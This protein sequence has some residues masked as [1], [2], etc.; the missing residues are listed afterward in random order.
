MKRKQKE[1]K[2]DGDGLS[3][4]ERKRQQIK[5][6]KWV[7]AAW[8]G[9]IV[10]MLVNSCASKEQESEVYTEIY[11]SGA[12]I[13]TVTEYKD[14][15]KSAESSDNHLPDTV[16]ERGIFLEAMEQAGVTDFLIEWQ[17]ENLK[18]AMIEITQIADG[19]IWL[20]DVWGITQLNLGGKGIKKIEALKELVLSLIHI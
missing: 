5:K 15:E 8:I 11:S 19:D 16:V 9:I 6:Q 4:Q 7:Q 3:Y 1:K 13:W 10:L 12:G 18:Q 14:K 2:K 17:D 20:S